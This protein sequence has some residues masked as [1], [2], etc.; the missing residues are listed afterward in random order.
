MDPSLVVAHVARAHV[1]VVAPPRGVWRRCEQRPRH[2]CE[3]P[4]AVHLRVLARRPPGL[5]AL[6]AQLR[7]VL[8]ARHLLR[9]LPGEPDRERGARER[10]GRVG[11]QHARNG[12]RGAAGR[13]PAG[14]PARRPGPVRPGLPAAPRRDRPALAAAAAAGA[15]LALRARVSRP[16]AAGAAAAVALARLAPV[17]RGSR[18]LLVLTRLCLLGLLP[19]RRLAALLAA[20]R[21]GVLPLLPPPGLRAVAVAQRLVG[22]GHGL[23]HPLLPL[24]RYGHAQALRCQQRRDSNLV[25]VEPFLD[26]ASQPLLGIL[27][28]TTGNARVQHG[29]ERDP[30]W[31]HVVGPHPCHPL[32]GMLV[33]PSAGKRMQ[34]SVQTHDVGSDA[35]R[36]HP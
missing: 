21:A 11:R 32:H 8:G 15:P 7:Q 22:T 30:V 12:S 16:R 34:Q 14:L 36:N 35:V 17:T 25:R 29:V 6:V 9:V 5:A 28:L 31:S 19:L 26:H 20:G 13:P 10:V 3:L 2:G 4:L 33:G 24:R 23:V 27:R 1:W 18:Q